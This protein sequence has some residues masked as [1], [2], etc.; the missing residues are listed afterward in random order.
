MTTVTITL[1]N[2]LEQWLQ[3]YAQESGLS[4]DEAVRDFLKRQLA[5]YR[6]RKLQHEGEGY[7][8]AAGFESEEDLL[9]D[10]SS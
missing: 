10:L 7:A 6:F 8:R 9:N 5:H 3:A 1:E 2:E 4:P